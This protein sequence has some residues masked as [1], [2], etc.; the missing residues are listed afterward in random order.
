MNCLICHYNERTITRRDFIF[1]TAGCAALGIL[2]SFG[3]GCSS[4]TDN[5]ISSQGVNQEPHLGF[6]SFTVDDALGETYRR[7][8]EKIQETIPDAMLFALRA[9]APIRPGECVAWDY[10][11]ASQ[12]NLRYYIVFT[13]ETISVAELGECTMKFAEWEHVPT[14]DALNIDASTAW[15]QVCA[16]AELPTPNNMYVYLIL[17]S[18]EADTAASAYSYADEPMNWYFEF[19]VDSDEKKAASS[20]D[21]AA[22]TPETHMTVY[23]V[24]GKTGET[25]C[26]VA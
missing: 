6:D 8:L 13:G 22:S 26:V 1:A 5:K 16:A 19:N 3:T 21:D 12:K 17:Y 11:F 15:E 18:E 14:T 10:M 24:D 2:C 25:S 9:A 20:T 23:S 4:A 7:A